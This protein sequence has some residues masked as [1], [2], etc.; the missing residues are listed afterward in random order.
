[1]A[2]PEPSIPELSHK[3]TEADVLDSTPSKRLRGRFTRWVPI[4]LLALS[5]LGFSIQALMVRWLTEE[6]IGT[7]QLL[8]LRGSCQALGC[9]VCLCVKGMTLGSWL[10]TTRLERTALFGRAVVGYGGICFGFLSIS[11]MPLADSQILGQ[12]APIFS[13]GFARIFLKEEWHCSEFFS[14][15]AAIVGV[16]FISK[17]ETLLSDNVSHLGVFFGLLSAFSAGATYVVIRFLGTAKVDW[18]SVLLAQ[19]LGQIVISPFALAVSGQQLR[20]FSRPQM[21]LGLMIGFTGFVS[22]IAMTKGMQKEKSA[23]ASLIRQSLCPIFALAWQALFFPADVLGWTSFAG[24]G[25]ILMGLMVTVTAK[26]CREREPPPATATKYAEVACNEGEGSPVRNADSSGTKVNE[27]AVY[28][29]SLENLENGVESQ[30]TLP[31]E[32]KSALPA[33]P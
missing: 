31:K 15:L 33:L 1:M 18:A 10:G 2:Q 16:G 22:Q 9:C 23:T 25:T 32:A 11:L 14:A 26:A 12:T 30:K 29:K 27:T 7:F 17:P 28:G 24:F 5:A 13:A 20:L 4:I 8:I 19:A 21:V 6:G 3:G